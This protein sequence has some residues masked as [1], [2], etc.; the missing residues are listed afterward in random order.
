MF[1]SDDVLQPTYNEVTLGFQREGSDEGSFYSHLL[2]ISRTIG[3]V[4]RKSDVVIYYVCGLKTS[5]RDIVAQKERI[6]PIKDLN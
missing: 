3:I 5:V 6:M 4:F 2:K 1:F